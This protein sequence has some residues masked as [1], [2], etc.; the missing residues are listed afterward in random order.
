[1]PT[2]RSSPVLQATIYD[3]LDKQLGDHE[4]PETRATL[5]RL[6]AGGIKQDEARRLLACAIVAEIWSMMKENK[7]FD[8]QRFVGRLATLPETPWLDELHGGR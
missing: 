6:V 7:P 8:M 2:P 5:E 1:M 3:I 4:P